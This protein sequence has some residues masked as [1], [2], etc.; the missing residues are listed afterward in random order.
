MVVQDEITIAKTVDKISESLDEISD[1]GFFTYGWFKTLESFGRV[2]DP[3]YLRFSHE[4]ETIGIA[5]CFIDKTDD[6]FSWGPNIF[7]YFHRLLHIGHKLGL[8]NRDLLL[9][10]SPAC[11]RTKILLNNKSNAEKI[12]RGFSQR[13]DE[14]C[15]KEKI[16]FSSFLFVSE[17]DNQL[18]DTL[19]NANYVKFT[20]IK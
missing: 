10:Y 9:C 6:F 5:P 18:I 2:P 13:I 14:L 1:D 19:E 7:P 3:Y 8:F 17:F 16:L 12:T 15:K 4:G 11:C 20:N